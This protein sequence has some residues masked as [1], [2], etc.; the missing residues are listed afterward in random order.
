MLLLPYVLFAALQEAAAANAL[1]DIR[2]KLLNIALATAG[3][4]HLLVLGPR[5]NGGGALLP[6]VLGTWALSALLGGVNLLQKPKDA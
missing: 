1:S 2:F 6:V 3:L 4:G 5:L